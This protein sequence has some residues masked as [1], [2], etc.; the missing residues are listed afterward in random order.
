MDTVVMWIGYYVIGVFILAA[1][2]ALILKYL[3]VQ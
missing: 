1:I 3:D 2:I